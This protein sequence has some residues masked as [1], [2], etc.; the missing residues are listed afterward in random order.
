MPI[1]NYELDELIEKLGKLRGRHTELVTVLIPAGA[2]IYTIA[3]QIA[4]E[5]S[6][7]DN[8][9]SKTT[10]KNVVTAL[11]TIGRE[12]KKYKQTPPNGMALYCGNV[13]EKEGQDDIGLWVIEPPQPLRTRMYRCDQTF[14][15]DPLKEMRE[16]QEIYGLV[17]MDR[18]EATIGVLEGKQIRMIRKMSSG[19]PGKIRAGGQC[20]NP[21]TLIETKNGIK[22]LRSI[23]V[24]DEIKAFDMEYS[25]VIFTKCINKWE[26]TKS[27]LVEI[28]LADSRT[29]L[30]SVDHTLFK[31]QDFQK[32]EIAAGK[33]ELGDSLLT[34]YNNNLETIQIFSLNKKNKKTKLIDIE[35]EAGNFF[36][37]GI[38][39]HNSAQRFERITEGLAKEFFRRISESM[40][41]IFF[42]MPKLKGILIGG[43]VPTKDE[44]QE[45]GQLVTKLKEKVIGVMDLGNTD[46]SG[47]TDLVE[48][49]HDILA[50]QEIIKEKK[51]M[52]KFFMTLGKNP[53]MAA[54]G[55]DAVKK[56]L[57]FG[58]VNILLL[59]KKLAKEKIRE[60]EEMGESIGSSVEMVSVETPEGEQF[61]NI[62]GIGALLRFATG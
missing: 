15:L 42:D 30:S 3:D 8:I 29:I 34:I 5:Q 28:K 49:S 56:A 1:T 62:S 4:A 11:E 7:A 12:L 2:N 38:L 9:K 37:N 61:F 31:K 27:R 55:E 18:K 25:K 23:L 19:V 14:V 58:A 40:K 59:S 44:F 43:P 53:S 47:L 26:K 45:E 39:V 13:S 22:E 35:T 16:V 33:L 50:N 21:D 20:L 60:L 54:Y 32:L 36:A 17:V 10:R 48:L 52:E 57:K 24:G 51:L 6:T 46:E 41:E